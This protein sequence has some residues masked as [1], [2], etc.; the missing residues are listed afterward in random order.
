MIRSIAKCIQIQFENTASKPY[1]WGVKLCIIDIGTNSLHS[2]FAT[3][4]SDGTFEI[5]GREKELVRLGD[6]A[7][8]N[9]RL[10][11]ESMQTALKALE[12]ISHLSKSRGVDRVIAVSTS[13]VRE[14]SNGSDFLDEIRSRFGLRVKVIIGLE[15]ARLIYLAVKNTIDLSFGK[16][17]IVDIGGGSTEFIATQKE[18]KLWMDSVRLGSNRLSQ[19]FPLSE[20]P[21][22]SEIEKLEEYIE[23]LI[24]P[25]LTNLEKNPVDRIVGTSGTLTALAK[26]IL[27][28][29][30]KSDDQISFRQVTISFKQV[31]AQYEKLC[32]MDLKDRQKLRG[33]DKARANM[34]I[35]GVAILYVLMKRSGIKSF[36]PCDQ[37]L[38]EGLLYDFIDKNRKTL[39]IEEMIPDLRRRSILTLLDKFSEDRT[40]ALHVADLACQIFDQT[41][42]Q[43]GLEKST[44]DLLEY[45]AILHDIGYTLNFR[46]HHRHSFYIITNS[47]LFGFTPDE[48]RIIAWVARLHRRSVSRDDNPDM[49]ELSEKSIDVTLKLAAILR[50]ADALD[51][52]HFTQVRQVRVKNDKALVR[53]LLDTPASVDWEIHEAKKRDDLFRKITK[54]ETEY[55]AVSKNF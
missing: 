8:L 54:C 49:Q 15:E 14:S 25:I 27:S 44:R 9:G 31:A 29:D 42:A 11:P 50:I 22:K 10:T 48:I 28:S 55:K 4:Y 41:T 32:K 39:R 34:I 24:A 47:E 6:G 16:S 5:S 3:I 35:Q 40:H 33:L 37:A 46:R 17:L 19:I 12:K 30:E 36:I 45:A 26:M 2:V 18:E 51:H 13:A 53:F 43:H 20:P 21:K 38:R 23:K 1:C 52:S 7:M